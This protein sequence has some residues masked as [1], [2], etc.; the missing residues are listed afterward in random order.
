M[1]ATLQL[2]ALKATRRLEEEGLL[3][4]SAQLP[5]PLW[6]EWRGLDRET[7]LHSL[8]LSGYAMSLGRRLQL[9]AAELEAVR[10]GALVHDIGK[11]A[12]P[13]SILNKPAALEAHEWEIVRQHPILGER[14][15]AP[16]PALRSV[17]G[18]VRHHHERWDGSGY[19]DHLAGERIPL[20]ARIVQLLDIFDALTSARPYKPAWSIAQSLGIMQQESDRRILDPRLFR[21][22]SRIVR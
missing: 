10:L 22:F 1:T 16:I 14:M 21:E 11:L 20:G 2:E 12:I 5:L 15:C 17:L 4:P 13:A 18:I 19:P 6:S 8:R 7:S 3:F 9:N